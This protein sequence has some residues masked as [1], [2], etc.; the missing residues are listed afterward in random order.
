MRDSGSV[1]ERQ[2]AGVIIGESG[3]RR[4]AGGDGEGRRIEHLR[5]LAEGERRRADALEERVERQSAVVTVLADAVRRLA[6]DFDDRAE[7]AEMADVLAEAGILADEVSASGDGSEEAALS[8]GL[9]RREREVLTLAEKGTTN[10]GIGE[11]LFI[12]EN[13][14]RKHLKGANQALGTHTKAEAV[15]A[16]RRLGIL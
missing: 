12:S 7:A 6:A 8:A 13:T 10:R 15:H 5:T 4:P 3:S 1:R 11:A 2:E 9:T 16:A 14:V